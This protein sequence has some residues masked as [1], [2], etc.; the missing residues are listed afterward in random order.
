RL[1][2]DNYPKNPYTYLLPANA[3]PEVKGV[4]LD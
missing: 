1:E 3:D 4:Y 2:R